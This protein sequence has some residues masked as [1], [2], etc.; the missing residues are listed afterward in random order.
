MSEPKKSKIDVRPQVKAAPKQR[1]VGLVDYSDD[2]E[3]SRQVVFNSE[4]EQSNLISRGIWF[5]SGYPGARLRYGS[6]KSD[7]SL[8]RG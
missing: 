6:W 4:S 3:T 2:E 5:D 8:Q 1:T 7:R